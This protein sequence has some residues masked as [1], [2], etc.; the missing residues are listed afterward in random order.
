MMKVEQ[1]PVQLDNLKTGG[2][3]SQVGTAFL[4]SSF[5][6]PP[7][8]GISHNIAAEQTKDAQLDNARSKHARHARA[9]R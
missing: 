2:Q 3:V 1:C 8:V 5:R 9:S 6:K 4:R 7:I